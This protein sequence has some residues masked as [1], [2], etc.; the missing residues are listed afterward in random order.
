MTTSLLVRGACPHDCPDTCGVVTEVRDGRAVAFRG[1]PDHPVARGWLVRQGAA[2][3]RS[4]L[5]P[6]PPPPPAAPQRAEGRRASGGSI[7]WDEAIAE[8]VEPLAGDHR[9]VGRGGDPAVQLQRHAR[10]G[11]ER[12]RRGA[13]LVNRL[14]ASQ[15]Q[16]SICGAAAEQAVEGHARQALERAL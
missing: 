14:G 5:P 4:R 13:I 10:T 6:R 7:T 8:I 3:P 12:R 2:L 15:L 16:R 1:D 11:A 9:R